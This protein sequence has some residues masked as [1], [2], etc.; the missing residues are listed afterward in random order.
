MTKLAVHGGAPLRTTPFPARKPYDQEDLN[1]L[2]EALDSQDLFYTSGNKIAS[3]EREFASMY[4]A[5]HAHAC[6]SGT[7]AVHMAVAAL[8][9][10]PGGEIITAPVTDFGSIAGILFQGQIPVFADWK[11]GSM[12]MDPDSIEAR[13]TERTRAILIVHLFGN[14][15]NM[16]RI[17][18]IARKHQLPVIE[19]CAQAY[20]TTYQ[21][22]YVGTFGD[23]ATFSMQQ[24]KHLPAGEGGLTITNN[25][26]Y[27]MRMALFRDKGWENRGRWGAR[28]YTFLGLNYRMN[29]LTGAVALA[30]LHKVESV[31]AT[32]HRLG[33]LLTQKLSDLPGITPGPAEPKADPSYWLYAFMITG[34]DPQEFVEALAAEGVPASW[35]YTVDPVYLCTGAL[36]NKRTFGSASYPFD[37]HYYNGEI[38]YGPGLCPVAERELKQIGT[39]RIFETWSESDI[40]DI[41]QAFRKVA[42]GLQQSL[43][44]QA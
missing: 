18:E 40:E 15:C 44:T 21:G 36:K 7:A 41:A 24:S 20:C 14:P 22:R 10:D 1:Y 6:S 25:D 4:N 17:M 3:L 12:N 19:D 35:G 37:S 5:K 43:T 38:E 42:A 29:E 23:I 2:K 26:G 11:E 34:Y 13:I 39:L 32:M 9:S 33:T 31:V 8:N 27:S 16:S 30:Q 28:S